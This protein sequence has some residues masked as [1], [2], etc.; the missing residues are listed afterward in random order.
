MNSSR[1]LVS[2]YSQAC[3]MVIPF[4]MTYKGDSFHGIKMSWN[5]F[6]TLERVVKY[7]DALKPIRMVESILFYFFFSLLGYV[8]SK[9]QQINW[10]KSNL[11]NSE[12]DIL[13]TASMLLFAWCVHVCRLYF[14]D[15]VVVAIGLLWMLLLSIIFAI[16]LS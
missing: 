10:A 6:I 9:W 5:R 11:N 7:N 13:T 14:V 8:S 2:I 15:F 1:L 4:L 12:V 16:Y 3:T